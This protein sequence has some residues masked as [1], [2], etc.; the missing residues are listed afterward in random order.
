MSLFTLSAF[1]LMFLFMIAGIWS[2]RSS[3]SFRDYSVAGRASGTFGVSGVLLGSLVG[4]A[5][6]VGTV[7]MAYQWGMSAWWFTLGG[8]LGCLV[9][10]LW[11]AVP[12][13]RSGL[14]TI[15]GFL[16]LSYGK[17][18]ATIAVIASV[19]G[20]FISI[21][22]QFL[23]GA[24]LLRGVF[25]AG[26]ILSVVLVGGLVLSFIFMG[27]L[28]SFSAIGIGKILI[29]YVTLAVC[30]LAAVRLMLSAGP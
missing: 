29:L 25:P 30:A 5:S 21:I 15:P 18:T 24:A 23:S 19:A 16:S 7:Q 12:L 28:K 22:A 6:T 11:F 17:P 1:L 4:G 8:G 10:G 13:R 20:T 27:G 3:R 2:G 26:G 14:E 9:L